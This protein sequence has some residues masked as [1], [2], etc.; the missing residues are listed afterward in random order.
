MAKELQEKARAVCSFFE[1]GAQVEA[2]KRG[3]TNEIFP[4]L[5]PCNIFCTADRLNLHVIFANVNSGG[6]PVQHWF[7]QRN[8]GPFSS[9]EVVKTPVQR[10]G[11]VKPFNFGIALAA[12]ESSE[13]K[14]REHLNR[15]ARKYV[16]TM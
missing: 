8:E 10:Y 5:F 1:E 11:F 2:Q 9:E 4:A 13:E 16:E 6:L 7:D 15:L 14:Q 3:L 12:L